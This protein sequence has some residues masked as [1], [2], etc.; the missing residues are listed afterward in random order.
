MAWSWGGGVALQ[1]AYIVPVLGSSDDS[2][3]ACDVGRGHFPN[4]FLLPQLP[5]VTHAKFTPLAD[6]HGCWFY[7][8]NK[9]NLPTSLMCFS[10][11]LHE[12]WALP[13]WNCLHF[14]A[15]PPRLLCV[16]TWTQAGSLCESSQ[17]H[18]SLWCLYLMFSCLRK[19]N[20]FRLTKRY[21]RSRC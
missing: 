20:Y 1:N 5:T 21:M 15:Q 8:I 18:T 11:S 19:K 9:Q 2:E 17:K 12:G 6:K 7:Y 4:C 16:G 13:V 3:N 14:Q 10:I